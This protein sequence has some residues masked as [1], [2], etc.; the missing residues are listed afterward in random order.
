MLTPQSVDQLSRAQRHPGWGVGGSGP[1]LPTLSPPSALP[2]HG[3]GEIFGLLC[4]E[5][6]PLLAQDVWE[7]VT[8][9]RLPCGQDSGCL[10]LDETALD[11]ITFTS[12]TALWSRGPGGSQA[13]GYPGTRLSSPIPC[14]RSSRLHVAPQHI[15]SGGPR[16][17]PLKWLAAEST[18]QAEPTAHSR[19][20]ASFA[21]Y[22]MLIF[23]SPEGYWFQ[24]GLGH[25]VT[26]G[27][28]LAAQRGQGCMT[29]GGGSGLPRT[30]AP[31]SCGHSGA[32]AHFS[33][34]RW[35]G[36]GPC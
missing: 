23:L 15:L 13:L 6:C 9:P 27:R 19:F 31:S 8:P 25:C 21:F 34:G 5:A 32:S 2:L 17:R 35:R 14:P 33:G 3:E 30:A 28:Y 29:P 7:G 16:P 22:F 12:K 36:R 24:E 1:R 20:R 18:V 4:S 10:G 11:S 26:S